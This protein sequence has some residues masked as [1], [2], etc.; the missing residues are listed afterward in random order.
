[1][2]YEEW[3]KKIE[4]LKTTNNETIKEELLKE[5]DNP[6][7][8]S[9]LEPKIIELIEYKMK[10]TVEKIIYNLG[11]IYR[12]EN[13]LDMHL[14]NLKKNLKFIVELTHIKEISEEKRKKVSD[15]LKEE[16]ASVYK[17]L[18]D[19]AN[20]FDDIGILTLTIKNNMYEWSD[21]NEL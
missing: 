5:P 16:I 14:I 4:I 20:E 8:K 6:N 17:I 21:K 11:D 19:G 1:M 10:K 12:D 2:S 13:I 9:F 18:I 3:L 15:E 7:I